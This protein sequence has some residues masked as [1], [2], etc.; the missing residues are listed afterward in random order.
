MNLVDETL[1]EALAREA[2]RRASEFRAQKLANMA[3][4]F[5]TVKHRRALKGFKG[6]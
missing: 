3:W 4:A 1:F 6:L 2:E 5:A